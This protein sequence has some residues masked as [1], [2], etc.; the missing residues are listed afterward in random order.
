VRACTP[1]LLVAAVAVSGCG[2]DRELGS[3]LRDEGW[4]CAS[5]KAVLRGS[6]GD[7]RIVAAA[8]RDGASVAGVRDLLA[9]ARGVSHTELDRKVEQ[10]CRPRQGAGGG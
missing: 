4:A 9:H 5:A 3:T 2:G 10:F 6:P 8:V 1:L 7:A